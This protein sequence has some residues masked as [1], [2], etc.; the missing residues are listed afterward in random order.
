M[1]RDYVNHF[2]FSVG[3]GDMDLLL[4]YS[5]PTEGSNPIVEIVADVVM[6]LAFAAHLHDRLA[7]TIKEYEG[8]NGHIARPKL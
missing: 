3:P 2:E 1:S 6:T 4:G 8:A 5:T 7:E